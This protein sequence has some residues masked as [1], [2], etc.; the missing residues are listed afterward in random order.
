M[1]LSQGYRG[2][3]LFVLLLAQTLNLAD[4]QTMAVLGQA[5]KAE[6]QFSDTQLGIIQGIGFAISTP[7]WEH[8]KT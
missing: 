6:L 5:M 8:A 3:L 2:W 4:R 7:R 1:E